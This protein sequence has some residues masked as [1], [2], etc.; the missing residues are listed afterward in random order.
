VW[1]F[2][3]KV[4]RRFFANCKATGKKYIAPLLILLC[5]TINNFKLQVYI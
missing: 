4:D 2:E 1:N 3:N 5:G